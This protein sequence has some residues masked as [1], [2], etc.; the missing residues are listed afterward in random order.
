MSELTVAAEYAGSLLTLAV[1]KGAEEGALLTAAGIDPVL[2][3]TPDGR[4]PFTQFRAL[5]AAAKQAC[6]EPALAL[7][8]GASAPF[9]EMSIVGLIAYAAETMGE[10]FEQ[11]NRYAR[12]VIEVEG[13]EVASR[14]ALVRRADG[15][16]IEDRRRNPNAFPE[17]TESTWVRF[18]TDRA[19]AFPDRAPYVREVHMTHPRPAHADAYAAFFDM[20][21]VFDAP[22]NA[23]RIEESWL[24]EQTGSKNRYVFGVFSTHADALLKELAGTKTIRGR[25]EAALIPILHTGNVSMAEIARRLGFSR[26]TLHRRLKAEDVQYEAI[27]DD[28]RRRMA[29]DYLGSRKVSVNEAA[30]LTGFPA[31]DRHEPR[32]FSR[33][34]G[35]RCGRA[36]SR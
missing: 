28:L 30:Y 26:S 6:N 13:H 18:V 1:S 24:A 34:A 36:T 20:P 17:L 27:L 11:T 12:L 16:W 7:H 31:M 3:R 10:A 21:V 14:F 9:S 32:P 33:R 2:I 19:R 15:V 35:L 25:I 23:L 22:W 29:L 8:F 4:L 5:M